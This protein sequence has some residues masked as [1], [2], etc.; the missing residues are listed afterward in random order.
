MKCNLSSRLTGIYAIALLFGASLYKWPQR[1]SLFGFENEPTTCKELWYKNLF[2]YN[3][4]GSPVSPCLSSYNRTTNCC[5]LQCMGQTWYLATEM[6][7]FIVTP[8]LL[9]PMWWFQK[10]YTH[11][12]WPSTQ[13]ILYEWQCKRARFIAAIWVVGS[14]ITSVVLTHINDLPASAT[15]E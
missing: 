10:Y 6:Q 3:N 13:C 12:I 14:C 4:K 1:A 11:Y 9:Y 8:L 5:I 15:V 2:Y 7:I